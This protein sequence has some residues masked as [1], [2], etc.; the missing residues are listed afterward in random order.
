MKTL[1]VG[2]LFMGGL[3]MAQEAA[4]P[5]SQHVTESQRRAL[6]SQSPSVRIHKKHPAKNKYVVTENKT[7]IVAT[8]PY[9]GK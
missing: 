6:A 1:T 3:L 5:Q 8:K 7:T 9:T 4:A 2:L